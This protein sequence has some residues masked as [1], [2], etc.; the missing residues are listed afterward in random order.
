MNNKITFNFLNNSNKKDTN[1]NIK[2]LSGGSVTFAMQVN[3]QQAP[4]L[5]DDDKD[6]TS[7]YFDQ[8]LAL[9]EN[10]WKNG[11]TGSNCPGN[12]RRGW[13]F[14]LNST[15]TVVEFAPCGCYDDALWPNLL[16]VPAAWKAGA[17]VAAKRLAKRAKRKFKRE[18]LNWLPKELLEIEES[19]YRAFKLLPSGN[20]LKRKLPPVPPGHVRLWRGQ[21]PR[22]LQAR[23]R[24]QS[25]NLTSD[26][27]DPPIFNEPGGHWWIINEGESRRYTWSDGYSDRYSDYDLP[28]SEIFYIDVPVE[29][30]R[31]ASLSRA[32]GTIDGVGLLPGQR[33]GLDVSR[34]D[35]N[36]GEY[37]FNDDVIM[38][39]RRRNKDTGIIDESWLLCL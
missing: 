14:D 9:I 8:F 20:F 28:E 18:L 22:R 36:L 13:L 23:T 21:G 24:N 32:N 16:G 2:A 29:Q 7:K 4:K 31:K 1:A 25:L 15:T 39:L 10:L 27:P 3:N 26:S 35:A 5:E 11:I 30:A 12:K 19:Y 38:P 34:Y 17:S 37:V 6:V 33:I